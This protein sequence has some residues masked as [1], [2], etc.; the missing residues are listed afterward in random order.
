MVLIQARSVAGAKAAVRV[1]YVLK[2]ISIRRKTEGNMRNPWIKI[3]LRSWGLALEASAV[4]ALRSVKLA[5][6][7][8]AAQAEAH[9]MLTEKIEAGIELQQK[10][11]TGALGIRPEDAAHKVLTHYGRRVRANRKRLSRS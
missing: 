10:A 8:S 4:M 5:Q 1:F 11:L 9:R 7:G 6:G 2:A 3:G